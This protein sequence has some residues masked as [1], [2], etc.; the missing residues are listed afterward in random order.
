MNDDHI[1]RMA[2]SFPHLDNEDTPT[3]FDSPTAAQIEDLQR[4][5]TRI[6]TRLCRLIVHLGAGQILTGKD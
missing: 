4:T 6:E 2:H 3:E 5:V 1:K